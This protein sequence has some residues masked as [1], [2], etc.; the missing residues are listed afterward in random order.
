MQVYHFIVGFI[1][2]IFGLYFK[3]YTL[4][5]KNQ[6]ERLFLMNRLQNPTLYFLNF[7]DSSTMEEYQ[8]LY[9]V[10]EKEDTNVHNFKSIN[11]NLATIVS[12]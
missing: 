12:S 7:F 2:K 6:P 3:F 4:F 1:S 10:G 9:R 11:S 5:S 8:A